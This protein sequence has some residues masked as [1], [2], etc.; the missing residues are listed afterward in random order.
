MV[1]VG[2]MVLKVVVP[3]VPG[4]VKERELLEEDLH[5]IGCH[6]LMEKP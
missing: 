5:H 3:G 4:N 6:G 2:A 1:K